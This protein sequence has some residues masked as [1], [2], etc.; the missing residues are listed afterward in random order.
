MNCVLPIVPWC[1]F[2]AILFMLC[3]ASF[4]LRAQ[5][6]PMTNG[7]GARTS[8]ATAVTP[9]PPLTETGSA[10][11]HQRYLVPF[12]YYKGVLYG[13]RN[14]EPNIAVAIDAETGEELWTFEIPGSRSSMNHVPAVTEDLVLCGGQR[15]AA[16]YA[17]NRSDGTVTWSIPMGSSYSRNAVLDGRQAYIIT[18]S[19]YCIGLVDGSVRWTHT[20]HD[21]STPTIDEDAVYV[22]GD[23]QVLAIEKN[24]GQEIWKI[25]SMEGSF[26]QL[27]SEGST[28]YASDRGG[29]CALRKSD[30]SEVWNT[31]LP[32]VVSLSGLTTGCMALG[33]D[34]LCVAIWEDTSGTAALAAVN[35]NTGE[36][37]W[38]HRFASKGL[39]TPTIVGST[40]YVTEWVNRTLWGLDITNG[41]VRCEFTSGSYTHQPVVADGKLFVAAGGGIHVYEESSTGIQT[42]MELPTRLSLELAPNPA[43]DQV[44]IRLQMDRRESVHLSVHDL[45]GREIAVVAEGMVDP[46]MH[47][48][49]WQ[50]RAG[51]RGPL[52][53]GIY[54][55]VV[56]SAARM[57]MRT[58]LLQ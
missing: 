9:Q 24:S 21:S 11:L 41:D 18:D 35:K 40:V 47:D 6:W 53:P 23:R 42:S 44:R 39:F 5:D 2:S 32:D 45:L 8:C 34:I 50:A 43:W 37:I 14:G 27:I 15:A 33:G 54:F 17:L 1:R 29:V 13:G 55:V 48:F 31:E 10:N 22:I 30:G 38:T 52:V 46:G 12:S 56:R 36:R 19:L 49:T 25:A 58:L 26:G 20:F 57:Q 51:S 28:L 7:N 3:A 4:T 16:L